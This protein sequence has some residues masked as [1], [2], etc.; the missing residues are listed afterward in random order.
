MA[1][2]CLVGRYRSPSLSEI[3]STPAANPGQTMPVPSL[4]GLIKESVRT[5]SSL[6][7]LLRMKTIVIPLTSSMP[8]TF[9]SEGSTVHVYTRL[10]IQFEELL[11]PHY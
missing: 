2:D 4:L 9:S 10:E 8:R 7:H 3:N 5:A 11:G 6:S 1:T